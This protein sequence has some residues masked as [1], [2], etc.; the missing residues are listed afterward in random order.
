MKYKVKVEPAGIALDDSGILGASTDGVIN[1]D[2]I[3]EVK[4]PYSARDCSLR[5][6]ISKN[7]NFF[8]KLLSCGN[9]ALDNQH[10]YYHQVQGNLCLLN[11]SV[12]NF[13]VWTPTEMIVLPIKSDPSWKSNL[14]ILKHFFKTIY[15]PH[16]INIL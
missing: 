13:I 1:K 11:A 3:I 2:L 8:F 16:I 14:N 9:F 10:G 6:A 15:L 5:D 12:C 4:C 7:K